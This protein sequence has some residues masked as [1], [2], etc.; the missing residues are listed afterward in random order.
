ML[1]KIKKGGVSIKNKILNLDD[2][3]KN[4]FGIDWKKSCGI[5]VKVLYKDDYYN[6]KILKAEYVEKFHNYLLTLEYDSKI[7]SS[8]QVSSFKRCCFKNILTP[9]KKIVDIIKNTEFSINYELTLS[10]C[11]YSDDFINNLSVGSD[12]KLYFRCNKCNMTSEKPKR[13][14]DLKKN[15]KIIGCQYCS[16]N[17]SY[18]ESLM[19]TLLKTMNIEFYNQAGNSK[20]N[21]NKWYRYDFYLPSLNCIIETHGEQHYKKNTNWERSL[22]EEQENDR[23]KRELALQN[24]IK[25]YIELDCRVSSLEWIKNSILNSE[26]N[27]LFDLSKVDWKIVGKNIEKSI[28]IDVCKIWSETKSENRSTLELAKIFNTSDVQIRRYLKRGDA[29]GLCNYNLE[30]LKENKIK[31][32]TNTNRIYEYKCSLN[33]VITIFDNMESIADF[34]GI[35]RSIVMG[36][37][38]SNKPY[39]LFHKNKFKH[40]KHI[41]GLYILKTVKN[42]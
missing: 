18:P 29:I 14:N 3:P 36:I 4:K 12:C 21:W 33:D 9:P 17:I 41:E 6:I 42:S 15:N 30:E 28:V 20:I 25:H 37:V 34:Y 22:E 16:N 31:K 32:T 38:N 27:T 40:L 5:I 26:L 13:F 7:F 24:G 1:K 2:L 23:L 19:N 39:K 8:I 35:S 11:G 10:E